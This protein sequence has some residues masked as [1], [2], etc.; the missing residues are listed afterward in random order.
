MRRVVALRTC[1][2]IWDMGYD[3]PEPT[4]PTEVSSF[5]LQSVPQA[6]AWPWK[7]NDEASSGRY[8]Q[9]AAC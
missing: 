9:H 8:R 1:Y 7:L 2:G 5:E 4:A 6:Q 3:E